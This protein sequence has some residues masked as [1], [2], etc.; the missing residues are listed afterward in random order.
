MSIY[1]TIKAESLEARKAKDTLKASLLGVLLGDMQKKSIDEKRDLSEREIV[2][3]I[4][5]I[6]N[7]ITETI[8]L[9]PSEALHR[10]LSI[11][12]SYL[13]AEK[14]QLS[15]DALTSVIQAIVDTL[16]VKTPKA[17]G[18]V[19]N[20]LKTQFEGQY[21]GKTAADIVKKALS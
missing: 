5:R 3:L 13:P 20:A 14:E 21:D 6:I 7:G 12:E 9:R 17:M 18:Q 1:T 4:K 11:L 15:L 16:E 19:I 2:S 10:E 8:A